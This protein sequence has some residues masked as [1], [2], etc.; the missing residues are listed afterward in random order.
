MA[1]VEATPVSGLD[2]VSLETCLR[3]RRSRRELC[4]R[5]LGEEELRT[6]CW[7]GQGVTGP[8]GLRTAPSA[9]GIHPLELYVVTPTGVLHYEA[10]SDRFERV[11][12]GDRRPELCT[13]AESQDVVGLAGDTVVVVAVEGRMDRRYGARSRRYELVEAGHVGQNILLAATALHL[14]ASPVGALDDLAV[15]EVLEL[16]ADHTPLYLIALGREAAPAAAPG[17]PA[18]R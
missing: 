17:E 2:L 5:P 3:G 13:A 1:S 10:E 9:G 18:S 15:R 6:L 4:R 11:L 12:R 7:A 16:P 8:G 14:C